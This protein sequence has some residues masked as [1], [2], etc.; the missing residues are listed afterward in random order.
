MHQ[1]DIIIIGA[2]AAGMTAAIYTC[3]KKLKTLVISADIGGQTN[4][5]S[6]IEN[7][8]G[9]G[10]MHGVELMQRF[11]KDAE[12]FGA[13]FLM[14]RVMKVEKKEGKQ[15]KKKG[16]HQFLV[17]V[18]DGT[19][20]Q[21]RAIILAFG[22]V[23]RTLGIP[24]EDRFMGRGVSTCVTCDGP[25]FKGKDVAVVGGGNS[26]VE[27]ALELASIAKKIYV[28]HR[29]KQ[30]TADEV[31]LEKM[32]NLKKIELVLDSVVTE[33]LGDKF[34]SSIMVEN[35]ISKEKKQIA[36]QGMF[37]EIGYLVDT[38]MVKDLVKTNAQ[39]EIII[40]D[41]CNTSCPGIFAAGDVTQMP[42]KQ[43]VVSAGEGAKAAL[44]C[45]RWLRGGKG[46]SIDWT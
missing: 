30:F 45:H 29:R 17:H 13:E 44:E 40:D 8:P 21:A 4:L 27:A 41:R 35:V 25:L 9:S 31:S 10:A 42:Y 28:I 19:V 34:V 36:A 38:S 22:K 12:S 2:G 20:F 46:I 15:E 43:T 7:Y 14:G 11:Q 39:R 26:A 33:V 24:G 23:S 6:H 1:Y 37:L 3:R 18:A 32:R 5:T 16:D